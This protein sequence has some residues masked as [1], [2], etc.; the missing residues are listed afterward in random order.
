MSSQPTIV[1]DAN[2]FISGAE[3]LSMAATHKLITTTEVLQEL[4][5]PKTR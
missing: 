4:R 1:L 3:L 5:D 2:A